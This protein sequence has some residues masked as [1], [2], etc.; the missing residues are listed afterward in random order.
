MSADA[1]TAVLAG[2][3]AWIMQQLLRHPDGVISTRQ[4]WTGGEGENP[5]EESPGGNAEAVEVVFDPERLSYRQ[6][7]EYFFQVHRADLGEDLVGSIYR[8]EIFYSSEEQ[9]QVAEETIRDV[10]ASGHWPGKTVTRVSEAG[11][12]WEDLTKDQDYFLRYPDYPEG[13]KPPFPRR[14][15]ATPSQA[16]AA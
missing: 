2:G 6:L 5:T 3:C 7:L 10:D 12:F 8:S 15:G 13:A 1:E 9:R 14:T 16:G 4:G 11:R